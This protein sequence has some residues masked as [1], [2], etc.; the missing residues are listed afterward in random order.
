MPTLKTQDEI[1]DELIAGMAA[2]GLTASGSGTVTRTVAEVLAGSLA[3]GHYLLGA[4]LDGFFIDSAA[5]DFLDE[6]VGDKLPDGRKAG[7]VATGTVTFSRSSPALAQINVPL[8]TSLITDDGTV[9]LTTTAAGV[10]R[11]G[12]TFCTVAGTAV[13]VGIA[14]NLPTTTALRIKGLGLQGVET[15]TVAAPGFSG[16]TDRETDPQLRDRYKF[17]VRNPRRSG[18]VSDYK[19]WTLSRNGVTGASVMPLARGPGTV[20]ILITTDGGIPSD[21]LVTDV[22]TYINGVKPAVDDARVIKPL[23]VAVNVTLTLTPAANYTVA[24]LTAGVTAAVQSYI[25]GLDVG[26]SLLLSRLIVA[27]M[28]VVGVAN[29]TVT[30]PAADVAVGATG[31]AVAGE[32]SVN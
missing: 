12:D 24:G 9:E 11:V 17:E 7:T 21:Q 3:E 25:S 2:G 30:T 27:A 10:I 20:D 23:A 26:A 4:L 18:S 31:K 14:C 29:C 19:A 13:G 5:G 16:G 32:V 6:R 1:R 8:G 28:S 15:I 22:Q